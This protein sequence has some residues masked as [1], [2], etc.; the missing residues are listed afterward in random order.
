YSISK[1]MGILMDRDCYDIFV[2]LS[3]K[4]AALN[5]RDFLGIKNITSANPSTLGKIVPTLNSE[6]TIAEAAR[7]MSLYRLRA[8]PVLE[9]NEITGQISAKKIVQAIRDT[10][11]VS[12]IRKTSA[13]DIMTPSPIVISK[14]DTIASA[15]TIMKRRRIDHLPVLQDNRLV[16]MVTSKD[17][18]EVMLRPERIGRKSLGIDDTQDRLDIAISGILDKNILTSNIDDTLQSVTDLMV[19]QNSTYCVIKSID[20]VQGIITYRDIINLLGEKVEEEI[21][22]FLI[23][24]PDDPLDAELAKSKFTNLVKLLKKIYPD[25][26]QARCRVKIRE[27]QGARKRYEVD[28]SIISTHAVANF[29]NV[30]WDLPKMFDQMSDSLKKRIAHRVTRKQKGLRYRV[31]PA[32]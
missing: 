29:V 16:G 17:I 7:L 18:V 13:S 24:L 10:M 9:K 19:S 12:A 8:L 6:S 26:E 4:V 1:I 31:R 5:I 20:E 21:P 32:P 2:P 23:G 30:G 22:I 14:T 11:L 3:G 25:I 28:A 27:I 15:K